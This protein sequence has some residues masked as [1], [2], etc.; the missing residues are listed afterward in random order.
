LTGTA[1]ESRDRVLL[2]VVV[3]A[4]GIKGEVK[5]KTFTAAPERIA[6]YGPLA[7]ESGRPLVIAQLRAGRGGEAI[8]RFDGVSDR[9]SAEALKGEGLYVARSALPE[10]EAGS[11]YLADLIGLR[12]EDAN[13]TLLGHVQAMHNFGAGDVLEIAMVNG[14]SEF[15]PF[16]DSAVPVVDVARGRIIVERSAEIQ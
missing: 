11:F 12:A 10:P 4:H 1:A 8:V 14:D 16:S 6:A 15:L 13:G 3:N 5:V 2:G 9:N 7:T